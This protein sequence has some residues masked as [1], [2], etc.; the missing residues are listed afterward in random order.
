M[1]QIGLAVVFFFSLT[2]ASV[3]V[4]AAIDLNDFYADPTVSISAEGS[5][6]IL[7]ESTQ[8]Q[9]V[10]LVNDPGFGDS[11][12]IIAD[13]GVNLSFNYSFTNA[14]GESDQFNAFVLDASTGNSIGT[15]YEFSVTDSL[16][17]LVNFNL[18][19]LVGM[20]LGLQFELASQVGD[21]GNNSNLTISNVRLEPIE[22]P[23]AGTTE[24]LLIGLIIF[25]IYAKRTPFSI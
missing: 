25:G 10:L 13:I 15:L 12:I 24:L 3:A 22:V 21:I 6:A 11:E 20:T 9:T 19:D 23:T 17:G 4:A 8:L 14:A 2:F 18:S 7:T 1:R 16:T 5:K